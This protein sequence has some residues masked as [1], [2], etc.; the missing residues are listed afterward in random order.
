[1]LEQGL[2]G[3]ALMLLWLGGA[4]ALAARRVARLPNSDRRLVA[5]ITAALACFLVISFVD[6]T[7]RDPNSVAAV[8]LLTGVLVSICVPVRSAVGRR[9]GS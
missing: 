2:V 8:S 5:G 6:N 9:P 1:L 7:L 4:V 3:L